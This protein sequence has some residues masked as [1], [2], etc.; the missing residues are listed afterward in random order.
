MQYMCSVSSTLDVVFTCIVDHRYC[1][2]CLLLLLLLGHCA[3]V[4]ALLLLLY[5]VVKFD[6]SIIVIASHLDGT[7]S[8]EPLRKQKLLVLINPV[9]GTGK[10]EKLFRGKVQDLFKVADIE[11]DIVTTG[12]SQ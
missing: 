5:I 6:A 10:S 1:C 9:S 12:K 2:L 8:D 4:F 11:L 3:V 7:C